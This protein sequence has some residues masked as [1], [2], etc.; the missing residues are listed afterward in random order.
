MKLKVIIGSTRPG[1]KGPIMAHW[2]TEFAKI[3][4]N[5]E[6]QIL[7]L[8]TID[9]PFLDE[10]EHPKSEQYKNDHTKKWSRAI[11]EAD[12]YVV[13][14]PEY[15]FGYPAAL[16]NAFDY[17]HR[18][19][20]KKPMG[21][22]SYGGISAGTRSVQALKLPVTTLSMMPLMQ[23]VNIPFFWEFI[24]DEGVFDPN[25]VTENAARIL[26]SELHNWA[27]ALKLMREK[28]KQPA[29]T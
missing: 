5:F 24:N 29:L 19:W 23:A 4:S 22:V 1:R 8:K 10:I 14:T 9:L 18:E 6:V 16:K 15:N 28:E 11:D 26:L 25:A 7:D 20:A 27:E 13:V 12:A 21:F 3:N 17:L 2:F